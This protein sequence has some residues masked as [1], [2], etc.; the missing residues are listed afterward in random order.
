MLLS[1]FHNF[2]LHKTILEYFNSY[3]VVLS[4]KALSAGRL[5]PQKRSKRQAAEVPLRVD[6][7]PNVKLSEAG[8]AGCLNLRAS[9]PVTGAYGV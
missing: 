4:S 9:R 5:Q 7:S 1:I 6:S 2:E 8:S 3:Y